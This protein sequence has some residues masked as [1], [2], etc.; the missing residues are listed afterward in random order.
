MYDET[1]VKECISY[2]EGMKPN[3][4]YKFNKVFR[5]RLRVLGKTDI[6]E[7]KGFC[8]ARCGNHIGYSEFAFASNGKVIGD[9][10]CK[11][12]GQKLDWSGLTKKDV[13]KLIRK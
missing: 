13:E 7:S 2:R 3:I 8:C 11:Y 4:G 10:F 6:A 9:S 1:Y 5:T 12:C